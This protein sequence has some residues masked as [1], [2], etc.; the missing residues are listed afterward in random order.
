[1][2]SIPFSL[3]RHFS[4][5]GWMRQVSSRE[6]PPFT[7]GRVTSPSP[8]PAS[9][10]PSPAELTTTTVLAGSHFIVRCSWF[11]TPRSSVA[12]N[13]ASKV[14]GPCVVYNNVP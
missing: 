13:S 7:S 12:S 11:S 6:L 9:V 10:T 3:R 14:E 1:M 8:S 2:T 4:W 5:V